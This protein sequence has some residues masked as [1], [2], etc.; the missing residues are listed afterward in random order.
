[1][2]AAIFF[3]VLFFTSLILPAQSDKQAYAPFD[4]IKI[5]P[6]ES[7]ERFAWESLPQGISQMMV[8]SLLALPH[9]HRSHDL[10]LSPGTTFSGYSL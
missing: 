6:D 9:Y 3:V 5:N 8:E 2:K 1:M 7:F 10:V 4:W